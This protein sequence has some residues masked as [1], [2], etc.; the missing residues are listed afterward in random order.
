MPG[1]FGRIFSMG[2]ALVGQGLNFLAMLLPIVGQE[3]GQ[4]AY[5]M[6]PLALATVLSRT[7][8]LGFHSRYLTVPEDR[9]RAATSVSFTTLFSTTVLCGIVALVLQLTV[10]GV[11][12]AAIAGWTAF[13]V[14]TNGLYFMSVAVATQEQRMDVYSTARLWYGIVN[15]VLTGIVVFAVPFQAGLVVVAGVNPLVG[16]LLILARTRN[17]VLTDVW[18]DR[19]SL[20]DADH[21]RYLTGSARAT[22]ATFLSECGFQI[23]GF[24]TPFLGQY[25]EAW[26]VVVRLTGGFGTL[27]QQVIAPGFEARIAAAIRDGDRGATAR[28]CRICAA[29]GIGLGVLCAVVQA[30]ALIFSLRGDPSLTV[31]MLVLTA[32]Y[33]VASLSTNLS[34]K[35][36]LM[37]SHDRAFL[38]WSAG[39]LVLLVCLLATSGGVLLTGTVV[40][41]T[42]AAVVFLVIA[43][44]P[45]RS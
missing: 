1:R 13:L 16:A 4:L 22:G 3:T 25:Q 6:L 26:A 40:V 39:R 24:L 23:Q 38:G 8:I 10:P 37:K 17:R 35:I 12:G 43:L 11:T 20:P 41:Q 31:M 14:I 19:R 9:R 28:W 30:G 32:V 29:G 7:S 5:L 44:R 33:C 15:I 27:A 45:V 36:P 34:V 21:R 18:R 2:G 42:L